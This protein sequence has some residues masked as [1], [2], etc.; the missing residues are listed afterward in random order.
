MPGSRAVLVPLLVVRIHFHPNVLVFVDV[1]H[2]R[3][4]QSLEARHRPTV[5]LCQLLLAACVVQDQCRPRGLQSGYVHPLLRVG[6]TRQHRVL[7]DDDDRDCGGR[8]DAEEQGGSLGPSGRCPAWA[9]RHWPPGRGRGSD[10]A[11]GG[12][13][14]CRRAACHGATGGRAAC[15][16]AA[17]HGATGGRESGRAVARVPR[18][19]GS[20]TSNPEWGSRTRRCTCCPSRTWGGAARRAA[21]F[22]V[23]LDTGRWLSR[24]SP[25][26]MRGSAP[27]DHPPLSPS[28]R[29]PSRRTGSGAQARR[30]E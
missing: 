4:L 18:R 2:H 12:R 5:V 28:A 8:V 3:L 13:A 1:L 25:G 11:R 24:E 7:P 19:A 20:E 30:E 26:A 6:R 9:N 27:A 29:A 21:P 15:R 16:R 14:A 22:G 17:C 23:R 10:G